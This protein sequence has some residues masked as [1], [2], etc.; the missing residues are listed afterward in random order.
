MTGHV[1]ERQTLP[2]AP[3][4]PVQ[5]G[6]RVAA[7][8]ILRGFAS[9]GILLVNMMF[10]AWPVYSEV[11]EAVRWTNPLDRA[12][13][14][15]V[16]FFAEG[17]FFTLFSFLFGLGLALQLQRAERNGER[18]VPRFARRLGILL[19]FGLAHV[20]LFWWGD[21][22][23]YYALLGFP[24]LLCRNLR[25]RQ[26]LG[27]ALGLLAVPLLL[28]AALFGLVELA[29]NTPEGA[30]QLEAGVAQGAG[31]FEAEYQEALE[32]YRTGS[33]G[34]MIVQRLGDY[35]F[36]TLGVTLS[37]MLFIVFAM[38][39]LGLYAGKRE[40]FRDIPTHIGFFRRVF[41]GCGVVGLAGTVLYSIWGG[42]AN[43]LGPS[44]TGLVGL[45][46]YLIG[47]PA[48]S[49]CYASGIVLL[50][51]R[52]RALTLLHP[53][54]AVGRT[55]LSNYFLQTLICTTLFYGYGFGLYGRVGPALCFV[56]TL[57][58]FALQVLLSNV[59]VQRFR[60][61]PVEWLW[62]SLTY[63]KRQPLRA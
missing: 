31:Q 9:F 61:G 52:P 11:M 39:L 6:E 49:L 16:G 47:S 23:T 60:F 63:G 48:L 18:V 10:F 57:V 27:W 44:L 15:F 56:L 19:L 8:D 62:R 33:F 3:A 22:L 21:I 38:F 53:L 4:H 42:T 32:V 55:A 2:A 12:A 43:T 50:T 20:V 5:P 54:A 40:L 59:W 34:E 29:G 46:G 37:G 30:A 45:I 24:L 35:G 17:K 25:P 13:A 26:L 41:L 58:I 36:A 7:L 28:N 51:Q 14:W 1:A